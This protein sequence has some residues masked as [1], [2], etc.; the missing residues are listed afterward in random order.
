MDRQQVQ[1]VSRVEI[2]APYA[3]SDTDDTYLRVERS[4]NHI[5]ASKLV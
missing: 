4:V 3:F 1:G 2:T 5:F